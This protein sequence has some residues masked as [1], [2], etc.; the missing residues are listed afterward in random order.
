MYVYVMDLMQEDGSTLYNLVCK[1]MSTV[2]LYLHL[3][4]FFLS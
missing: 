2:I 4:Y 3:L 1:N